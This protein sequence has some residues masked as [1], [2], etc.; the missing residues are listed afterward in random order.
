MDFGI[1]AL[2]MIVVQVY[3]WILIASILMTWVP[4]I[5]KTGVGR[6]LTR[7]T[8]PYFAPFR[9]LVPPIRAGV[10]AI[11][12]S[13]IVALLAYMFVK[14]GISKILFYLHL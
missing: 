12:F 2:V 11:D 10:G 14:E 3:E 1:R 8:E 6:F 4:D 9:R 7:V 5:S 13:P